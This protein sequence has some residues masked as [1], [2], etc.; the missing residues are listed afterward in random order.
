MIL[1]VEKSTGYSYDGNENLSKERKQRRARWSGPVSQS[2]RAWSIGRGSLGEQMSHCAALPPRRFTESSGMRTQPFRDVPG[3]KSHACGNSVMR[4]K[5]PRDVAIDRLWAD[6]Q[7]GCQFLCR[8]EIGAAIQAIED[9]GRAGHSHDPVK[10]VCA[11]RSAPLNRSWDSFACLARTGLIGTVVRAVA[12]RVKG[13]NSEYYN[14]VSRRDASRPDK[15]WPR[16]PGWLCSVSSDTAD[17][18]VDAERPAGTR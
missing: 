8:Q 5:V 12:E 7:Q 16:N 1:L 18:S 3:P 6:R 9:V 15:S 11:I 2:A 14:C 10:T 13:R 17:D 4:D